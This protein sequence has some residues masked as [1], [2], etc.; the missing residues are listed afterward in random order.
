MERFIYLLNGRELVCYLEYEPCQPSTDVD[1]GNP[2]TAT[3][4]TAE[5]CFVDVFEEL[6]EIDSYEIEA[7]FLNKNEEY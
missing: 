5:D 6:S 2:E 7:A 4:V 3:L 1:P